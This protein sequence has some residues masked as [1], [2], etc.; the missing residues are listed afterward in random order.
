M[1]ENPPNKRAP[2]GANEDGSASVSTRGVV[3][4]EMRGAEEG[5]VGRAIASFLKSEE[6]QLLTI[7]PLN[8]GFEL[9]AQALLTVI[10]ATF[11]LSASHRSRQG[12]GGGMPHA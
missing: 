7:G 9:R 12:R 8:N 10:R 2:S 6:I 1:I 3:H 4:G 11:H 5:E